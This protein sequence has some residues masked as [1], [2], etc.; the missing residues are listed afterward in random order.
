MEI[1]QLEK[2]VEW[3]D[4]ERRADKKTIASLKKKVAQLEELLD[5]SNEFTKRLSSDMNRM[6][7][8]MTKLDQYDQALESHRKKVK[9]E[10]D[11]YDKR[12]KRREQDARKRQSE[13]VDDLAKT[14]SEFQ[15]KF[16]TFANVREELIVR[17][18]D[19]DRRTKL[20]GELKEKVDR[21]DASESTRVKT[22]K[23]LEEDRRQDKKRI[24]DLQAE[25]TALRKRADEHKGRLDL[26]TEGQKR[27]DARINE[28]M[29]GGS[30]ARG[31]DSDQIEKIAR[32]WAEREKIWKEWSKKI[33]AIDV[34]SESFSQ[35]MISIHEAD[36][37]INQAQREFEQ[38]TEQ[39]NRRIHEITEMQRLGEERFRQEWST[40]KSDDQKRW[41]NYALTQEELHKEMNRRI[42]SL[43]DRTT[44]LEENTQDL[45]DTVQLLSEH[46]G[47]LLQSIAA[48]ARDWMA[49]SDRFGR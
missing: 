36:L 39:L 43:I 8:M 41:T 15:A 27:S 12:A 13:V 49:E 5:K 26:I 18:E 22:F 38:I 33:E 31:V 16:N 21:V 28:A 11:S 3:L 24:A 23:E 37:A 47:K 46:A 32:D 48:G 17:K 42:E 29:A 34:S 35:A 7:V 4:K 19:E 45:Q 9:E 6:E 40:F 25:V 20:I 10:L 14:L 30:G 2:Q 1:D 44:N